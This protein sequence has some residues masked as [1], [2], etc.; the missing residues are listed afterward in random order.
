MRRVTKLLSVG[1]LSLG[2]TSCPQVYQDTPTFT[3][4][5]ALAALQRHAASSSEYAA[6]VD[7]LIAAYA[8]MLATVGGT[9]LVAPSSAS[10]SAPTI[11]PA[12]RAS[13]TSGQPIVRAS[14]F[15]GG[16][17]TAT[18]AAG[19]AAFAPADSAGIR[20]SV[21]ASTVTV[22]RA[23]AQAQAGPTMTFTSGRVPAPS[24]AKAQPMCRVLYDFTGT[25][26]GE[27]SVHEGDLVPLVSRE[28]PD[29]WTV[30]V[31]GL[32]GYVPATYV[33]II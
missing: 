25:N 4:A 32:L 28:D 5:I 9:P 16:N 1:V 29:W 2:T 31:N 18:G 11:A 12:G 30:E 15:V 22:V 26:D 20:A 13:V 21:R 14:T 27:L 10:V 6:K 23:G 17:A 3:N 33:Q 19:G 7:T 8:N 24:L